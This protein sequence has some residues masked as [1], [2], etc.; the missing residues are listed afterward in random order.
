MKAIQALFAAFILLAGSAA[1][2]Q[3]DKDRTLISRGSADLTLGDLDGRMSRLPEHER[4]DYAQRPDNM[5]RLMDSLLL[6]RQLANE[7][8]ELGLDGDPDVQRD[9]QLAV[10]EVLAVHR[11]NALIRRE[12][13]PDFRQLA[14][15]H[16]LAD[17]GR[18]GDTEKV[19]V[20]HVLV[21]TETHG[22]AALE[23]ARMIRA[24]ALEPG[25]DFDALMREYSEDAGSANTA[26]AYVID[27]PGEYVAEFEAA[28]R[29][30]K[31]PGDVT[32]PVKSSFGYHIMK[33]I[34]RQPART[35]PFEEVE[36]ELLA[37][38][39][40]DYLNRTRQE[41]RSR[42]SALPDDGDTDLLLTLPD[43]Y[44]AVRADAIRPK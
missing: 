23:R 6:N 25:S 18:F 34:D 26:E 40:T 38:I 12:L 13:W 15:E 17:P 27:K 36:G 29:A 9:M 14:R 7:A 44:G 10:E 20:K 31:E 35:R 11:T 16:Y 24:K 1:S 39:R 41:H 4:P 30:L 19:T 32:E 21:K 22:D 33:L 2:A 42:L 43:R 37:Q 28:G 3:A 5:A 8:R